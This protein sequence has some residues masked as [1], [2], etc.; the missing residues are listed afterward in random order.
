MKMEHGLACASA[1]VEDRAI[2]VKQVALAGELRGNQ[3][4]LADH[5]LVFRSCVVQ[6]NKMFSRAQQYVCR[7][8]R[9]YI[10]E[11]E[12]IS[13]FVNNL[14]RNFSHG[15]FTESAVSAHQ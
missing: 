10:F 14:G 7:R 5:R 1:I 3:M 4:Q 6:R 11:R 2:T 13:V 15:N 8:L 9:A 12:K